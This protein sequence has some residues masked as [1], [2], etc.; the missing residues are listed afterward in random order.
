M[1]LCSHTS[2]QPTSQASSYLLLLGHLSGLRDSH[3]GLFC[4]FFWCCFSRLT[5]SNKISCCTTPTATQSTWL[6]ITTLCPRG[7]GQGQCSLLAQKVAQLWPIEV[8]LKHH[9][10]HWN[11]VTVTSGAVSY[12]SKFHWNQIQISEWTGRMWQEIEADN[13]ATRLCSAVT[14]W[15]QILLTMISNVVLQL[16]SVFMA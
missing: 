5:S 14:H 12:A 9:F 4:G 10:G 6:L 15:K 13:K 8:R 11:V 1:K 16:C 3:P 2:Q 7:F